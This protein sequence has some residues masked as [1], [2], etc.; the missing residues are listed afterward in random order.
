M[1]EGLKLQN[2]GDSGAAAQ[3]CVK[4]ADPA[5]TDL[6]PFAFWLCGLLQA[7]D[8]FY[9]TGSYAHSFGLEGL[10]QANVVRDRATLREF[11]FRSVLPALR[12]SEL[13]LAIHAW[14]AL[15]TEDWARL[16]E[17]SQLSAALNADGR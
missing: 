6:Q 16:G 7:G 4:M 1:T 5:R 17:I 3:G 8:S 11:V 9:P 15:E 2:I 14:K 13:P 12:Q 10:V